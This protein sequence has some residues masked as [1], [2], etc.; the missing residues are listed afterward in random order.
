MKAVSLLAQMEERAFLAVSV[1]ALARTCPMWRRGLYGRACL[2]C[3]MGLAATE[4]PVTLTTLVSTPIAYVLEI[5]PSSSHSMG[6]VTKWRVG[7]GI[8]RA[9]G[10]CSRYSGGTSG[11]WK[12]GAAPVSSGPSRLGRRLPDRRAITPSSKLVSEVL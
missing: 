10:S 9:G 4:S 7:T 12:T 11:S 1:D 2:L 5:S 6:R 8:Q 3:L